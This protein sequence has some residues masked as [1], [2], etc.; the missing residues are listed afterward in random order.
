MKFK[1]ILAVPALLIA[2]PAVAQDDAAFT[3]LH[4]EAVVGYDALDLG[5]PGV[6]N[7]DGV[8]YG[9]NLG[10]DV[11][12]SGGVIAGI[13]AELADSTAERFG[14]DAERDIYVGGRIGASLGSALVYAKAGYTNFRLGGAN[15]DGFRAGAGVEYALGG[16]LFLKGEYRYSNYEADVSRNQ[17][18]AGLGIRF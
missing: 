17:V 9:V 7:P 16:N 1:Y 6:N 13:E 14:V 11:A 18:V 2:A 8:L 15:G 3:G 10:Y 12:V 5:L 4:A